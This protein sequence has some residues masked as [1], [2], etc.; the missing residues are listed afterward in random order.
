MEMGVI[1]IVSLKIKILKEMNAEHIADGYSLSKFLNDWAATNRELDFEPSTQ[2]DAAS[3][4]PPMDD[5]PV[6]PDV[7]REQCVSRMFNISSY[8]LGKLKDIVSTNSGIQL[9][10]K[11]LQHLFINV[12]STTTTEDEIELAHVVAQLRKAKQ[13]QRDKLKDM[14]PDK[15]ALH[16]LESINVGVNIILERNYDP[17]MYSSLCNIGLYKTDFG[18]GKPISVTLARSP[19]KNNIVFLDDPSGEGINALITLTEADMLIFQSNKELL[20]FASPVAYSPE[21]GPSSNPT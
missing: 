14:S 3:F 10:L 11:L 16:A 20:E 7:V 5:P 17:Y 19:M 2:F 18:W 8:S 21:R 15:I 12:D 13:H 1:P 6:I 4:F 9:A